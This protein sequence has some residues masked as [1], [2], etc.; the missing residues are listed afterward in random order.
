MHDDFRRVDEFDLPQRQPLYRESEP[1][2]PFPTGHMGAIVD[3]MITAVTERTRAPVA[4][5]GQSVMAAMSMAVQGHADIVLPT[6]QRRPVSSFFVTVAETGERKSA[7]DSYALKAVRD[8]EDELRAA[9]EEDYRR[10]K[11]R[12][13]AYEKVRDQIEK[14]RKLGQDETV[15]E[16]QALGAPPAPPLLPYLI[17]SEPTF[18]GL[19]GRQMRDGHASLAVF[20]AEGGQFIGGVAMSAD[21]RLKTAAGLSGLWDGDP[22]RRVRSGE[23][24]SILYGRRLA[25][26]L[27]VQPG[28][29]SQVFSDPVLKDQGLLSRLMVVAPAPTAG[30]REW[31]DV[32]PSTGPML[33]RFNA[34]MRHILRSP[35]PLVEGSRNELQPRLLPMD[36]RAS[37]LWIA[38]YNAV[39]GRIGEGGA[40]KSIKG[41]GNKLP[42]HAARLAA[43]LALFDNLDAES[44]SGDWMAAG[45]EMTEHYASE[46]LRMIDIGSTNADLL[47]AEKVSQWA[48]KRGTPW[49]LHELY[50]KGPPAVRDAA[51]A[52]RIIAILK[53]HKH[54]LE[55]DSG[56]ISNPGT[57]SVRRRYVMDIRDRMPSPAGG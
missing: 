11:D 31:R 21:N 45:I 34:R 48:D 26:H 30:T 41:L 22:V 15:K 32:D 28:V 17:A 39:E 16:L 50:Q 7:V 42:E 25:F 2:R 49:R 14:N 20:S 54:L 35:M 13:A 9:Y 23:G 1:E 43:I 19:T 36:D 38:Y 37:G 8:Y 57:G 53:D 55:D 18:E 12:L 3:G 10:Y 44:L 40:Y 33:D 24:V 5:V 56:F 51:T 27:M 29:A 47:L 46:A 6:G 4:I 52:R